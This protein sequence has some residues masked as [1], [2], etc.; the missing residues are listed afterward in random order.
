M[1]RVAQCWK[2]GH[3]PRQHPPSYGYN[4]TPSSQ[5]VGCSEC[6]C[7]LTMLEKLRFWQVVG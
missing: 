5:Y 7:L 4:R 1:G 3:E 6:D 2:C